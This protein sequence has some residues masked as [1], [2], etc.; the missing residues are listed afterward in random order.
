MGTWL[1]ARLTYANVVATLALFVALGG[2]SYAALKLPK[3]SVGGTQLRPN[4]VTSP[5]VKPGSLVLSDFKSSD[6]SRLAGPA[7]AAG[8]RGAQ[9]TQG[10][11]GAKGDP[12]APGATNVVARTQSFAGIPFQGFVV[13]RPMCEAGERAVGGGAG[14]DGNGGNEELQQ[15]YPVEADM[16]PAEAGDT[17]VGW[18]SI[19]RNNNVGALNATG[20]AVCARP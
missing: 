7:G 2:S 11:P 12:G 19:I 3:G 18:Q 13:M 5:K 20:Y 15:S 6:R 1:R 16:S 9:G 17:P 4:A 8:A 14:F 10:V